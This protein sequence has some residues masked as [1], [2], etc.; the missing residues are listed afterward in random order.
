MSEKCS[1]YDDVSRF[2]LSDPALSFFYVADKVL[3]EGDG[4]R[5]R[6]HEEIEI[7]Y[8]ISGQVEILCGPQVFI[9]QAGDVVVIN[10]CEMHGIRQYGAAPAE[11]HLLMI[12]PS[13][14]FGGR[15]TDLIAPAFDGECRFANLIRGDIGLRDTMLSLFDSLKRHDAAYELEASG[16]L[17]LLMARLLR[18]HVSSL[19]KREGLQ[20]YA[21][22][23]R[24][25]IEYIYL[26]YNQDIRIEEL[27]RICSLSMYYFCR[28][29]KAGTGYTVSAYIINLRMGKAAALLRTTGMPVASVGAVVGY[30]DECYFSRCFKSW[31]GCSP[32]AYREANAIAGR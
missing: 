31:A 27:A 28:M 21:E 7:K 2:G 13:L 9:A 6:W 12:P 8:I 5:R 16:H 24:P 10:S 32:S 19:P 20:H 29:F 22:K 14:P 18:D 25:A 17:A 30:R 4:D 23:L 26:N 11:Y 15:L 1:V 3:R